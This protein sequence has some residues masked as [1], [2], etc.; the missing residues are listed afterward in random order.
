MACIVTY[1]TAAPLL[2]RDIA[3]LLSSDL[4][5]ELA[6]TQ[7]VL[8]AERPGVPL[9]LPAPVDI[10]RSYW[11]VTR[12]RLPQISIHAMQVGSELIDSANRDVVV[13]EVAIFVVVG[14]GDLRTIDESGYSDAMTAYLGT[15]SGLLQ[16]ELPPAAQATSGVFRIDH[17]L[18]RWEPEVDTRANTWIQQGRLTMRAYQTVTWDRP[19][20][21]PE[22]EPE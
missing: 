17:H 13:T 12:D 8:L 2:L 19:P 16:R 21:P 15:I 11:Q 4:S 9:V 20:A 1:A 5:A 14:E 18:L 10:R 6:A 7:A 3:D 22:P